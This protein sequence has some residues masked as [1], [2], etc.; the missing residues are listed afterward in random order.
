MLSSRPIKLQVRHGGAIRTPP[1]ARLAMRAI[2]IPM[3]LNF[4]ERA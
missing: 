1:L 2:N 3:N 4:W